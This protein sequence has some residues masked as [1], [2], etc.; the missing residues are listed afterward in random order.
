ME[1][2]V[3]SNNRKISTPLLNI[4]EDMRKIILN[5]KLAVVKNKGL[6]IRVTCPFHKDGCEN[7][8]WMFG[9]HDKSF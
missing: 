7:K 1:T 3:L 8:R 5:G 6:N 4:I 9:F 2:L